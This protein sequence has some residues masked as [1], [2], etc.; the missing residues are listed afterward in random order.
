MNQAEVE[1]ARDAHVG[2]VFDLATFEI[3]PEAM[4]QWARAAGETDPRFLDPAHPDFQAHPNFTTHCLS[5]KVLPDDFPAIGGKKGIDGGKAVEVFGPIRAGDVL[6]AS[7]TIAEIYTK[8]GRSGTM[9][10]IVQRMTF[11]NQ[12]SEVVSTVDWRMIR[13]E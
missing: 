13:S 11:T 7:A 1:E 9:L 2:K 10:F 3:D 12:R 5:N 6:E 4:V 8:T